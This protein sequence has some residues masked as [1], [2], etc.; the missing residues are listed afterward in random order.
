MG[1]E[2]KMQGHKWEP[3]VHQNGPA[4]WQWKNRKGRGSPENSVTEMDK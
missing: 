4:R 3:R 2:V 1:L